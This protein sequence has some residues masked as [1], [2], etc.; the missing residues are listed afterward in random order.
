M[1][2]SP[3]RETGEG[4][5]ATAAAAAAEEN[6]CLGVSSE[7][8]STSPQMS[9]GAAGMLLSGELAADILLPASVAET[10]AE[11]ECI[12]SAL[13]PKQKKKKGRTPP[14]G[15]EQRAKKAKTETQRAASVQQLAI[16]DR[17]DSPPPEYRWQQL[18]TEE[19]VRDEF[20]RCMQMRKEQEQRAA[21]QGAGQQA[22]PE[23]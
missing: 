20:G 11:E 17:E 8:P 7:N 1:P 6:A 2:M 12:A 19:Q 22:E 5:A 10:R 23:M 21:E 18:V 15:G 4:A 14:S 3:A 13:P 16:A 9:P